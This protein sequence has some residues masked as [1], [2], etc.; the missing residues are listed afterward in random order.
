MKASS[1]SFLFHEVTSL[2]P[3]SFHRNDFSTCNTYCHVLF[4]LEPPSAP[5]DMSTSVTSTSISVTWSAPA[6]L[7]GRS[8]LYY[9]IEIS[10]PDNLRSYTGT[11][12]LSGSSTST[13]LT[14]LRP[15][16]QYCVRVTAHN[17][18]SD[19]DPDREHL[20]REEECTR[21]LEARKLCSEQQIAHFSVDEPMLILPE[22]YFLLLCLSCLFIVHFSRSRSGEWS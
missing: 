21:T 15:Y 5:R 11:V 7:G 6:D 8:D 17:G 14:N 4:N 9:Q 12:Y 22:T 2:H 3:P 18:V 20:R 1:C 19:Q 16:T 10:D 13:A